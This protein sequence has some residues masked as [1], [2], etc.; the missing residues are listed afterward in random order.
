MWH[1]FGSARL[2]IKKQQAL[3]HKTQKYIQDGRYGAAKNTWMKGQRSWRTA[4]LPGF[5]IYFIC[6]ILPIKLASVTADVPAAAAERS[7]LTPHCHDHGEKHRAVV[8]EQQAH[9]WGEKIHTAVNTN[10]DKRLTHQ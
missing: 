9:L 7:E 8:I 5:F 2:R 10:T 3:E 4:L 6:K 1:L